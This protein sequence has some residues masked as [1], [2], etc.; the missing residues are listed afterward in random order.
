MTPLKDP[1]H[2]AF[3]GGGLALDRPR[4]MGI[5]NVTPDSFSDG[6]RFLARED[7][8]ANARKMIAHGA[9]V[10]DIGAE[11]TRP[12]AVPVP[13]EEEWRRL[14]PVL[15]EVVAMGTPVSIDTYKAPIARDACR[16]GAVI[17]NDVWGLQKDPGMADVVAEAGAAVIMMHNRTAA[18]AEIDILD[19]IDRFFERSLD[20]AER[21]GIAP[22][23]QMLDPGIGFGKT[24]DQNYLVLNRLET[25]AKHGRPLMVGASRKRL[26]GAVLSVDTDDRLYGSLAIHTV[27]MMKG[28]AMIRV[29]NVQP[30]ADA[31]RIVRAIAAEGVA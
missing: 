4:V 7:A 29:H 21:A 14:S 25:L 26:I 5:L 8:L 10:I 17:V 11:S 15:S 18:D 1:A 22:E 16:A 13:P 30:H 2:L 24:L 31:A 6:G 27:A 20:I 9:D 12:G 19:D 28:A 3:P 23:K